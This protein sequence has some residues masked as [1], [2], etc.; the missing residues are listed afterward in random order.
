MYPSW[1]RVVHILS[2]SPFLYSHLHFEEKFSFPGFLIFRYF[3]CCEY[4]SAAISNYIEV[5]SFLVCY[6]YN[7]HHQSSN[8]SVIQ[9]PTAMSICANVESPPEVEEHEG[10]GHIL[11]IMS[12][13]EDEEVLSLSLL[14]LILS[15]LSITHSALL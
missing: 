9:S 12:D 8:L 7:S 1:S 3:N 14:Q 5:S 2:L 10:R 15:S 6:H 4:E 13:E 11:I